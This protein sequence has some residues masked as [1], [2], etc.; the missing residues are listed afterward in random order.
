MSD[1]AMDREPAGP[2]PQR[3][4]NLGT[5][6]AEEIFMSFD[7]K[8]LRRFFAFLKPHRNLLFIAQIAIVISAAVTTLIPVLIGKAVTAASEGNGARLDTM[9][10]AFS[11]CVLVLAFTSFL[12]QWMSSRLAQKV[13][14]DIRRTMF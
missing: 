4:A 2:P 1:F 9:L 5:N 8:V 10:I 3:K 6:D 12:D 7:T 13:I 14:F 11:I